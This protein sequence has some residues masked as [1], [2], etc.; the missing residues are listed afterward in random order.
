MSSTCPVL[1]LDLNNF[2][3]AEAQRSRYVLTSPRSLESCARLGIKPFE[4]LIKSL[5]ELVAEQRDVPF[6][7]VKVMHESYEKER[8]KLLQMCR[9]EREKIIQVR[10]G[11]KWPSGNTAPEVARNKLPRSHSKHKDESHEDPITYA[12]LCFK[13][14]SVIQQTKN[15]KDPDRSTLCS[16]SLGDLRHSPAT[17]RKLERITKAINKEMHVAVSE[18][19]RKIAALMLV[20]HKEEQG[21][22]EL[23]HKEEQDRQETRKK[24]DAQRIEAERN[25]RKRLKQS[26]KGWHRQLQAHRQI[27]EQVE[28][29]RTG[30]LEQEVLF[31][32]DRWRRLKEEVEIQRREKMKAAQKE[33]RERKRTQERL[34]RDKEEEEKKAQERERLFSVE[35]EQRARM[36]KALQ[37]MKERRRL[38]EEN[39]QE[40][41]RRVFMKLQMEQQVEEEEAQKRKEMENKMQNSYKKHA[42]VIEARVKELKERVAQEEE[43][44][45][46]AKL[47]A[48]LQSNEELTH[49]RI[50]FELS[51]RRIE[52]AT[53]HA[54]EMNK[55]KVFQIKQR[56]RHRQMCHQQLREK[57]EADEEAMR[58]VRESYVLMKE[59]KRE[60]LRRQKEQIQEEAHRLARASF[61]LRERVRRHTSSHT[62][63]QMRQQK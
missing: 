51:K 54:S 19:D 20:R 22:L 28:T 7:L 30:Q 42:D 56:N 35:R 26:M 32:E 39:R 4:L 10:N 38:Q 40:L 27:R 12:H 3:A 33:A 37:E 34:L 45:H 60:R 21:R 29:E 63:D 24:E 9:E 43:Q 18:M 13:G 17:E 44:I 16:F 58:Q 14:K 41:L 47:R 23:C 25:R 2:D 55:T 6:E 5:N 53:Q 1:H 48:K 52:R 31:H 46:R 62:F 59:W 57:I 11:D 61:H 49:K 50:L 36:S 8:K 15:N